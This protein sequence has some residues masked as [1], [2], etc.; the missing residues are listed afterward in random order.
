MRSGALFA[1]AFGLVVVCFGTVW[2]GNP[3]IVPE[4]EVS[5]ELRENNSYTVQWSPPPGDGPWQ[6]LETVTGLEGKAYDPAGGTRVYRVMETVPASGGT[7][8]QVNLLEDS[9]PGFESGADSWILGAT[10]TVITSDVRSGGSALRNAIREIATGALLVKNVSEVQAGETY[11][12]SFWA[13]QIEAGP[14]Y[15]QHYKVEWIAGENGV[16]V[17]TGS[18]VDFRGGDGGWLQTVSPPLTAPEGTIGAKLVFYFATGAVAGA[19]GEVLLDDASFAYEAAAAPASAGETREIAPATRYIMRI[20]WPSIAGLDYRVEESRGENLGGWE[21]V[22]GPLAGDGGTI[23]YRVPA[24]GARGFY[25]IK[26]PL[27]SPASPPNVRL[28]T[29]GI[30]GTISLAWDASTSPGVTGY[31]VLYGLSPENLDRSVEVDL[32]GSVTL[33]DLQ[34]GQTYH[35]AVV[36]V[37]ADGAGPAGATV[38]AAQPEAE[39]VF[40]ALFTAATPREP[41]PV[42]E[43]STALITHL[44][45]RARDRHAREG[46]GFLVSD[47][48]KKS[49]AYKYD[50][51]LPF[52]WEQRVAQIE[53]VD[54]VAKGGT[55]VVF[56]FTTQAQLNPAEFRTFFNIGS[57][58]SGYHNNQS[59]YL[60][61]GVTLISSHPSVRYPGETDYNYTATIRTKFPE[62]R[63]LQVG[64]RMEVELSQFLLAPRNGR[65][66]YYG[67]AFLYVV[68]R[69]VVPWYAKDWEEAAV[70]TVGVT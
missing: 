53:I 58:L 54:E 35:V 65:S 22:S 5:W 9:N 55:R 61:A 38:L 48:P 4:T 10:Q 66:N 12:F 40:Q 43:T 2:A 27:L 60:N 67:T 15:V 59:D 36:A 34:E 39:P 68:G 41:D 8:V 63:P 20:G 23:S 16:T 33:G 21:D 11:T 24:D 25:R 6:D 31:R 52:Y 19:T 44:A 26:R 70:K 30:A 1:R 50:H 45:D 7:A 42:V 46:L 37:S 51:Y 64:D 56:N 47:G 18:W 62:G 32:S 13:K 14:S 57:P 49:V 3:S 17:A 69:G 28:V 29:T